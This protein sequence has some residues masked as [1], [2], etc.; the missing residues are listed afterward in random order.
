MD[1]RQIAKNFWLP[2]TGLAALILAF[3][4]IHRVVSECLVFKHANFGL[5]QRYFYWPD[6]ASNE[7]AKPGER[8]VTCQDIG[9]GI[10]ARSVFNELKQSHKLSEQ[11][12]E[13]LAAGLNAQRHLYDSLLNLRDKIP[14]H[15]TKVSRIGSGLVLAILLVLGITC[16]LM[17]TLRQVFTNAADKIVE[18]ARDVGQYLARVIIVTAKHPSHEAEEIL[19]D[20]DEGASAVGQGQEQ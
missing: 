11:Q 20:L 3:T 8:G 12:E 18:Q 4:P 19:R 17:T 10:P 14:A 16:I 6:E 1:I 15:N 13:T 5:A 7:K 2:F 9:R